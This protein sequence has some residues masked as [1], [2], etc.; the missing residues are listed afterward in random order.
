MRL[1]QEEKARVACF[2]M[3]KVIDPYMGEGITSELEKDI[4]RDLCTYVNKAK[5]E[6]FLSKNTEIR[7]HFNTYGVEINI[8]GLLDEKNQD[9]I[10]DSEKCKQA[11]QVDWEAFDKLIP[12]L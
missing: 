4:H 8:T 6:G 3:K 1:T 10:S 11:S 5:R 2:V 7:I 9:N 12:E